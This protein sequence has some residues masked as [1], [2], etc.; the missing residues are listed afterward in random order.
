MSFEGARLLEDVFGRWPSFH[1]AEVL[2]ASFDRSGEEGPTLV[3]AIHV[4]EMTSEVDAG[5][6]Y[7]LK[8]HTEVTMRFTRIN[9]TRFEGFNE[10]NVL[11][12]FDVEEIPPSEH[13]GRRLRVDMP[14]SYGLV[15]SFECER[16]F[17]IG[18]KPFEP[19][20]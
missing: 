6:C 13:D 5:G 4:F 1:D 7:V 15:C 18:V 12:S 16:A 10:Q 20:Q 2:H 3:L 14:T 11:W 19:R 17:V 9:L 8:H